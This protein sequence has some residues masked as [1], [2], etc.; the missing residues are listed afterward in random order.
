MSKAV[1]VSSDQ[2]L[3]K[4]SEGRDLERSGVRVL[5]AS[6]FTLRFALWQKCNTN[7]IFI[8]CAIGPFSRKR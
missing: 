7:I 1:G 2:L 6:T 3:T 4:A 8:I 5:P